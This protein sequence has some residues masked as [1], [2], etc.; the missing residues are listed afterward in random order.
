[1]FCQHCGGRS[2]SSGPKPAPPAARAATPPLGQ[3][4]FG[5]GGPPPPAAPGASPAFA[6]TMAADFGA[7]GFDPNQNRMPTPAAGTSPAPPNLRQGSQGGPPMGGP[8]MGG[9]GGGLQGFG[10]P[11]PFSPPPSSPPGGQMPPMGIGAPPAPLPMPNPTPAAMPRAEVTFG[12]LVAVNRDGSDGK[13]YGLTGEQIDIGR[14]EAALLFADDLYLAPRHARF[15]KKAGKVTVRALDEVN[16]V[17]ARVKEPVPL[18]NGDR[19]LLGK[20][21]FRYEEVTAD[22]R[23]LKPAKQNG[24]LVFGTP[25]RSPW[26]RLQQLITAGVPRDIYYLSK[27]EIVLG[28]EEGDLTF[29]DDEFMSRRHAVIAHTGGKTELRDNGSSNGTYIR[30]RGDR[31]LKSGDLIRMGDQLFRFELT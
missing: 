17:F 4:P 27:N 7:G 5:G 22:E 20:E 12:R 11:S 10:P 30:I 21:V 15:E 23:D 31:E 24:T 29:P 9:P 6:K 19:M 8:P 28:R 26:G 1:M 16:G 3:P 14:S 13:S 18:A 2:L 25:P